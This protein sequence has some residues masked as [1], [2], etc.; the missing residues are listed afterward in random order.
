MNKDLYVI[1]ADITG[2]IGFTRSNYNFDSINSP[3]VAKELID[4]FVFTSGE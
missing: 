4:A 3:K 1:Q 2:A